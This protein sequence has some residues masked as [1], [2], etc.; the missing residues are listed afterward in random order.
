ASTTGDGNTNSDCANTDE[1][2][3][4]ATT[5]FDPNTENDPD[6]VSDPDTAVT[7]T[8]DPG[9]AHGVPRSICV[10]AVPEPSV[11]ADTGVNDVPVAPVNV[12]AVPAFG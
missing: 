2:P 10:T 12:T 1:Y 8:V 7:V 9:L 6:V 5:T 4:P 3:S 11:V